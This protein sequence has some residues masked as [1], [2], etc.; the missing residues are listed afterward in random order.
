MVGLS[1][2]PS[3]DVS[4]CLVAGWCR[5][6]EGELNL[7]RGNVFLLAGNELDFGAAQNELLSAVLD[8]HAVVKAIGIVA[9]FLCAF[10]GAAL[11]A[12]GGRVAVKDSHRAQ[13]VCPRTIVAKCYGDPH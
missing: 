7:G 2:C 1:L 8:G 3:M 12:V 11:V 9:G 6:K 13:T 4:V 5:L 10:G